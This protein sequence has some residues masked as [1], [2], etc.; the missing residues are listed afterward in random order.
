MGRKGIGKR[1]LAR[2]SVREV[3]HQYP[4]SSDVPIGENSRHSSAVISL[5]SAL[6]HHFSKRPD[7]FVSGSLEIWL[8]DGNEGAVMRSDVIVALDTWRG[9]RQSYFVWVEGKSPDFACDVL[10][11]RFGDS[12]R[13]NNRSLAEEMGIREYVAYD[14]GYDGAACRM[15]MYRLEGSGYVAVA[16]NER[17]EFESRVLG[18]GIQ[19]DGDRLRVRDL[20]TGEPIPTMSK[21]RR[22]LRMER[23]ARR[24]EA[25]ARRDA[26]RKVAELQALIQSSS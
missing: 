26:E 23:Q 1:R 5:R 3:P 2:P 17:G 14:P 24:A 20:T 12:W 18:L 16:P 10:S 13:Y 11:G 7:V 9:E 8:E 19:P 4:S 15:K 25:K 22:D 21:L 6:E